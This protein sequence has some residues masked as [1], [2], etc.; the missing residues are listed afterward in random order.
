MKLKKGLIY[1]ILLIATSNCYANRL[2]S[3]ESAFLKKAYSEQ[4]YFVLDNQELISRQ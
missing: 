1:L 2:T 4:N 3:E